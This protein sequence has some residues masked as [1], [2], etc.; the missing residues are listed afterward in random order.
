MT[1]L[2]KL[3]ERIRARP[4][5]ARFND[6]QVLLEASGWRIRR[7]QGSHVIFI[8]PN[9]LPI[10]VAKEGGRWVK[11]VYLNDVCER[12]GLDD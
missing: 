7:E 10:V 11:R 1:Q 6:V 9:E 12:L 5:K 2:E 4:P 8:K 3:I